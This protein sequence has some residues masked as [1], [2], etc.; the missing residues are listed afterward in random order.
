MVN[1]NTKYN[2]VLQHNVSVRQGISMTS[3]VLLDY[4]HMNTVCVLQS[5]NN[6]TSVI[7]GMYN[8]AYMNT[9]TKYLGYCNCKGYPNFL[10]TYVVW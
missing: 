2:C 9:Q 1:N 5:W 7:H 4:E 6:T 8:I 10:S 3:V